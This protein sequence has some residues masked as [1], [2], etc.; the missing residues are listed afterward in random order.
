MKRI[1]TIGA[2]VTA[3]A[4][5]APAAT[6]GS[7]AVQV[8][9]QISA[10]VVTVQVSNAQRAKVAVSIQRHQAQVA[11]AQRFSLLLRLAR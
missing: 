11:Q 7:F 4:V 9:Q 10:Q 8:K 3:F 5:A 2:V 6:A 1:A